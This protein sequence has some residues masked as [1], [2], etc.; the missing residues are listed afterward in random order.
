MRLTVTDN[1]G[2]TDTKEKAVRVIGRPP[3]ASF[4]ITPSI[5]TTDT[6]FR[7]DSTESMD[8]DGNIQEVRW[9][10]ENNTFTNRIPL[11][12]FTTEGTF[13][14]QLTVIDDEGASDT[15][16]KILRVNSVQDDPPSGEVQ[17]TVP[18]KGRD[19]H[20]FEVIS[21]DRDA[22]IVTGRFLEPVSCSDVFYLCGDVRKGGINDVDKGYWIGVICEM[23]DLGNNTFR[24]HLRDGKDWVEVGETNTY[25][26]PQFDCN[27]DV[28]CR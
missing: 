15:L 26:W 17:C 10:I 22:K 5:G 28:V 8:P 12:S 20:L 7:F 24:I 11:Y 3:I 14:I 1:D 9:I 13:E 25:V 18:A 2:L 23:Y 16:T 27:P 21:E 19:Y 4:T 6:V